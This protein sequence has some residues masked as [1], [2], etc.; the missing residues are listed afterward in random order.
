MPIEKYYGPSQ[1][2]SLVGNDLEFAYLS[3]KHS[4]LRTINGIG[5]LIRGSDRIPVIYV[6]KPSDTIFYIDRSGT[7]YLSNSDNV[8]AKTYVRIEDD[9]PD[10]ILGEYAIRVRKGFNTSDEVLTRF[11]EDNIFRTQI[12]A[13]FTN[14]LNDNLHLLNA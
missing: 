14:N 1:P 8:D 2:L 3:I 9:H 4:L 13:E 12:L 7:W 11:D 6:H 5:L 10:R